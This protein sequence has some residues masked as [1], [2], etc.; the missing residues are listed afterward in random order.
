MNNFHLNP[1]QEPT[2]TPEPDCINDGDVNQDRRITSAD[3]QLAFLIVLGQF[4]PTHKEECA[5]DCNGDD[6]V[7]SEDAQ[8]IFLTTLGSASCVHPLP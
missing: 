1:G 7:T 4:S 6:R 5:A 2:S 8:L 3:A